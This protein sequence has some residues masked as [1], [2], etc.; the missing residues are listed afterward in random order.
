[1][2]FYKT[3]LHCFLKSHKKP[4]KHCVTP[5]FINYYW[6]SKAYESDQFSLALKNDYDIIVPFQFYFLLF[7]FTY[8]VQQVHWGNA[9]FFI[10]DLDFYLFTFVQIISTILKVSPP[11][12][13]LRITYPVQKTILLCIFLWSHQINNQVNASAP[14]CT[15]PQPY[16]SLILDKIN[17][18]CL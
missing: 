17:C 6:F 15:Q 4:T 14:L 10:Y 2:L 13:C 3:L 11:H 7:L 9:L 12:F 18:I 5:M 8:P 16:I 1:M